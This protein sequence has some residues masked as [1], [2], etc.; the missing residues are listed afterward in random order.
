MIIADF[1]L[2][3]YYYYIYIY[4]KLCFVKLSFFILLKYFNLIY[5]NLLSGLNSDMFLNIFFNYSYNVNFFEDKK[6]YFFVLM[7]NLIYVLFFVTLKYLIILYLIGL[8][9]ILKYK[10]YFIYKFLIIFKE[11]FFFG[12]IYNILNKY[13]FFKSSNYNFI[14][15]VWYKFAKGQ[16]NTYLSMRFRLVYLTSKFLKQEFF[17]DNIFK[18]EVQEYFVLRRKTFFDSH[19]KPVKIRKFV[20]L[21][22]LKRKFYTKRRRN[23]ALKGLLFFYLKDYEDRI[24]KKEQQQKT[25]R[26]YEGIFG[27]YIYQ[28]LIKKTDQKQ[29]KFVKMKLNRD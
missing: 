1:I 9:V 15:Q 4:F 26:I 18:D 24:N 11:I 8:F 25:L 22:N 23:Y 19:F 12:F 16:K 14:Y 7:L 6:I 3:I 20:P 2:I 28:E 21:I 27:T 13:F 5:F 17:N 10:N 29:A